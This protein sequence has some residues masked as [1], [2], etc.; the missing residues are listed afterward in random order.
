MTHIHLSKSVSSVEAR[1]K[2]ASP[3]LRSQK[4]EASGT[5]KHWGHIS[6]QGTSLYS[7]QKGLLRRR[8]GCE[9][10]K[11][12]SLFFCNRLFHPSTWNV[13]RRA[14]GTFLRKVLSN[15]RVTVKVT[16][17]QGH[18]HFP[19]TFL[20]SKFWRG[21]CPNPSLSLSGNKV[22]RSCLLLPGSMKRSAGTMDNDGKRVRRRRMQQIVSLSDSGRSR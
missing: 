5:M 8:H 17:F 13:V 10:F 12:I 15:L 19:S 6:L 16:D 9:S 20:L 1:L 14:L 21:L 4:P 11:G 22:I 18:K 2:E 3:P 7:G